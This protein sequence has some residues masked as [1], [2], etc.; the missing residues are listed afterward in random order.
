M[1][2]TEA[3]RIGLI[4][5]VVPES[6]LDETVYGLAERLASGP[7]EGDAVD[8]CDELN[9]PLKTIF[10]SHFD[11]GVASTSACPISAPIIRKP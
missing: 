8:G 3:E 1:T 7:L 6:A 5:Q 2:A 4:T 11:A 9:L 10:H